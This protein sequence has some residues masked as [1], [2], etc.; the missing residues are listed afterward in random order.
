MSHSPKDVLV[1]YAVGSGK[2]VVI[3]VRN[4][5][6]TGQTQESG[7]TTTLEA[8]V[9]RAAASG[10]TALAFITKRGEGSFTNAV[11]I[12]PY[13][14]DRADWQFVTSII[15]ATLQEKNKF[16]RPWIMKICRTTKSLAD[17]QREVRRALTKATGINEGVYTQL[18]AYLELIVPEIQRA[19]LAPRLDLMS[20]VV[21]VMDVSSY[22]TPMQML[23][24]Q[25]AIDWVNAGCENTIVVV[26]EAW[27][28][29]PEGKGS[30]VKHSAES[31]VRKGSGLGNR[32]WVDSQDMA[33][34][35]KVILRGCPVWL[36]GVQRE[37]NEIKRNLANIPAGIKRPKPGD[38]AQLKL[39]EF[40]VCW[41]D[42][43]IKTYV[44]PSWMDESKARRIALGKEY[45]WPRPR[46]AAPVTEE[47][48][49]NA[50]EARELR[51]ENARLKD[52]IRQFEE[53]LDALAKPLPEVPTSR[54]DTARD[55]AHYTPAREGLAMPASDEDRYQQFKRRLLD[56]APAIIQLLTSRPEIELRVQR[57]TVAVDE[58]S[59][60]GRVAKLLA[61]DFFKE[62]QGQGD[63]RTEL[64]QSGPDVNTGTL[65]KVF[66]ELLADGFLRKHGMTKYIEVPGMKVNVIDE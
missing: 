53:R 7:K 51:D 35:D 38:V 15:D 56:E 13:F 10:L 60:K 32:I 2:E 12:Q 52:K 25:S 17:V 20:G 5:A 46:H 21:H 43:A 14:R 24:V 62:P 63:T 30:P 29:I 16:L 49:V 37:A 45:A 31:L 33:G 6:V 57:K 23:F 44:R 64:R 66:A 26:P 8:L 47:P 41:G 11:R 4:L 48:Q 18:D 28:F 61:N 19:R 54:G 50:T 58:T 36:I 9:D 59:V 1:G 27:E 42:Q 39:G 3:P 40:Y 22:A 65:S 34:V 55:D